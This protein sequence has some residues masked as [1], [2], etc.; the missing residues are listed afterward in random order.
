MVCLNLPP[1]VRYDLQNVYITAM[2]PGPKEPALDGI[3]EFIE[4]IVADLKEHYTPGI[5]MA[6]THKYPR[7]R[8]VRSAVPITS[9]DIPASRAWGGIGGQSHTIFCSFCNAT[10][11]AID[12]FDFNSFQTRSMHE[13]LVHVQRWQ[14][15]RTSKEREL[16]W[17]AHGASY[18][19]WLAFPWWNVFT[20]T[21]VAPMHWTKNVLEKQ[22][23]ENM[24]CSAT[25]AAGVPRAPN[26]SRQISAVELAWGDLAL[27]YQSSSD[28]EKS[29]LPEPLLRHFCRER[30]IFEAG[31]ASSQMV[32]D[33]NIWVSL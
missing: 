13:H 28:L 17:K 19:P 14:S 33:L 11:S 20:G 26:L 3:N 8:K 31:L 24:G 15:A 22:I 9:L 6:K 5:L 12:N 23:H 27:L 10:L 16:V 4:P 1:D 32:N 18:S 30:G 7:G 2:I 25:N 21:T 29:K